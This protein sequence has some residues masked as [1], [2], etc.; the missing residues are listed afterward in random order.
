[1]VDRVAEA[2]LQRA[3]L[4]RTHAGG[5]HAAVGG[6]DLGSDGDHLIGSLAG[7]EDHL[8]KPFAEGPVL[9][10]RGEAEIDH[11]GRLEG[12]QHL[13]GRH[14]S[15][16]KPFQQCE[17]IGGTH[18]SEGLGLGNGTGSG[19]RALGLRCGSRF[20]AGPTEPDR[21]PRAGAGG[22]R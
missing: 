14:L 8:G 16:S 19:M 21:P 18:V 3:G 13:L 12:V 1:M 4:L 17:G 11:R 2:L 7:A 15:G 10:D 9:I 6:E 22:P 20:R 5:Q